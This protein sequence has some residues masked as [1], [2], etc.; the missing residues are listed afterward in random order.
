[1]YSLTWITYCLFGRRI[2]FPAIRRGALS[3]MC[4]L[5][6]EV[7]IGLLKNESFEILHVGKPSFSPHVSAVRQV[8]G[9]FRF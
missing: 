5:S 4:S 6:A 3:V 1:M 7:G 8:T 9:C 2:H